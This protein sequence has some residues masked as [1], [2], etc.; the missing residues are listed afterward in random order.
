MV[1]ALSDE[2]EI[3]D[4]GSMT[5]DDLEGHWQPVRSAIIATTG[6]LVIVWQCD[7]LV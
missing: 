4:L 5:L 1:Y 2:M 7:Y 6:L 3:N